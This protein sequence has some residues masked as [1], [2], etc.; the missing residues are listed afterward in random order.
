MEK[1]HFE[2]NISDEIIA[3]EWNE[4][5]EN[6]EDLEESKEDEEKSSVNIPLSGSPLYPRVYVGDSAKPLMG[7]FHES[8]YM[9]DNISRTWLGLLTSFTG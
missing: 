7:Q 9:D 5:L 6:L 1:E 2:N 8:E 4:G 3:I